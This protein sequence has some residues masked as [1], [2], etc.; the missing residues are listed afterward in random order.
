MQTE[1]FHIE[2]M[3]AMRCGEIRVESE[4]KNVEKKPDFVEYLRAKHR[5]VRSRS[6]IAAKRRLRGGTVRMCGTA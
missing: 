2:I 4:S 6:E 5:T 1:V 3:A